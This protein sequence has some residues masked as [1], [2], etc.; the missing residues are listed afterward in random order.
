MAVETTADSR[1]IEIDEQGMLTVTGLPPG[2][3]RL[4]LRREDGTPVTT[5]W[6]SV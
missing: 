3:F 5:S 2:A 6:I 4:R 1:R